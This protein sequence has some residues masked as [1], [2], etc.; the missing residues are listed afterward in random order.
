MRDEIAPLDRKHAHLPDFELDPVE[1]Q[2]RQ[3]LDQ[4]MFAFANFNDQLAV[5]VQVLRRLRQDPQREVQP[6]VARAQA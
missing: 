4:R 1:R 5:C 3:Q 2:F 6:V